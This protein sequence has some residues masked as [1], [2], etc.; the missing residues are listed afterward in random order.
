MTMPSNKKE[1]AVQVIPEFLEIIKSDLMKAT[2]YMKQSIAV[3]IAAENKELSGKLAA[4]YV[5]LETV[6][7]NF[8]LLVEKESSHAI[9]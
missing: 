2:H 6:T 4:Q 7:A 8:I 3:A 5:E 1:K 9:K